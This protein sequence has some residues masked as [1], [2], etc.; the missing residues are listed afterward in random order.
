M[1][2]VIEFFREF[3]LRRNERRLNARNELSKKNDD[4]KLDDNDLVFSLLFF[5]SDSIT[6]GGRDAADDVGDETDGVDELSLL[7]TNTPSS[8]ESEDA[9][10][11]S[12]PFCVV[13][14]EFFVL[15]VTVSSNE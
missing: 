3:D 11:S 8:I 10:S 6:E 15:F 9:T 5:R 1:V 4:K 7:S 14:L 13:S 12:I 2:M